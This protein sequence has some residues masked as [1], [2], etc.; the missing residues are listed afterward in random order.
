M[1]GFPVTPHHQSVIGAQGY[2]SRFVLDELD[3]GFRS[4]EAVVV[5]ADDGAFWA[6]IQFLDMGMPAILFDRNDLQ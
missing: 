2:A 6:G 3:K 1:L 5:K 4:G